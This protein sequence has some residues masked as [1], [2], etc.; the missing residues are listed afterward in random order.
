MGKK[1]RRLERHSA[2]QQKQY[3]REVRLQYGPDRVNPTIQRWNSCS[4]A[5]QDA[6]IEEGDQIYADFAAAMQAGKRAADRELRELLGRW[7][8]HLRHFYEPS[9]DTLRCLGQMYNSH[10]DFIANFQNIHADLPAYLEQVIDAYVDDLETAEI[11]RMLAE[12]DEMNNRLDNL[13][14]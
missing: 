9:L 5:R 11:E 8:N 10:P 4:Q 2:D 1:K 3:E 7:Q 14:L 6:I 13:S 12:D